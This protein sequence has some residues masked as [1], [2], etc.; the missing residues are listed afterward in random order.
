MALASPSRQGLRDARQ[1]AQST[2]LSD[3]FLAAFLAPTFDPASYLNKTLPPLGAA[4]SARQRKQQPTS[5]TASQ[6]SPAPLADV[7]VATQTLLSQLAAHTARLT[8][9]LTVLTDDILRSG[10]RLAYEVE[11]L[12]GEAL[13][14][15]ELLGRGLHNDVA[16]FVPASA[17]ARS[18]S[19]VGGSSSSSSDDALTVLA[20]AAEPAAAGQAPPA[21]GDGEGGDDVTKTATVTAAEADTE[22]PAHIARLRTLTHVRARLDAV[23]RVLGDAMA[24]PFPPSETSVSSSFLSVSA[25][26]SAPADPSGVAGGRG[27]GGGDAS[28]EEKG[29]EALDRLRAEIASILDGGGGG[30]SGG[31]AVLAVEKAAA[32]VQ[33]IK[34]LAEVWKGTAEEKGR[35]KFVATLVRMVEERHKELLR[36]AEAKKAPGGAATSGQRAG[37]APVAAST[38]GTTDAESGRG[39][40]A[41]YGL[42]SQLQKLRGGL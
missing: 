40:S 13:A 20:A 30:G 12:R 21:T 9:T 42:I 4:A 6:A 10:G 19:G 5:T 11:V 38:A 18:K 27:G 2:H 15:G 25:P 41:G 1:E 22:E 3:P 7:V 16:V 17:S 26:A 24:F 37:G 33:E 29:R 23:I 36:E 8:A 14:L 35:A 39:I 28:V 32:R 31:D 34:D